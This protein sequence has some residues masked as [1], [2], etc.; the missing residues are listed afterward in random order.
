VLDLTGGDGP[1]PLSLPE[2]ATGSALVE[3]VE[4]AQQAVD[5]GVGTVE[6]ALTSVEPGRVEQAVEQLGPLAACTS[7]ILRDAFRSAR[8]D[9]VLAAVQ[10]LAS[11]GVLEICLDDSAGEATPLEIRALLQEAVGLARPVPLRVSL[12]DRDRLGLVKAL[13]ALKSGVQHFDTTLAGLDGGLAT[14][15]LTRLL[16]TIDVDTPV[17][18]AALAQLAPHVRH[19]I[20][21]LADLPARR[22]DPSPFTSDHVG[23]AG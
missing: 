16:G 2:G 22:H 4:Q 19:R 17:D 7:V 21:E 11:V 20:A 13:T 5:L 23:A 9:G 18:A 3:T 8:A 12:E 6:L 1:L 15:D 10:V 14:E